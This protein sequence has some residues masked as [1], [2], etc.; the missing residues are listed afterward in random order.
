MPMGQINQ[1]RQNTRSTSK[2]FA[3]TSDL[4]DKTVTPTGTGE[5]HILFI[6]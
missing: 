6:L 5:K 3:I 1:K 2:A 4:E